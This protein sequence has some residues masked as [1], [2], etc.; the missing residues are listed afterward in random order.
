[1]IKVIDN[2]SGIVLN[3]DVVE[4][5]KDVEEYLDSWDADV[6]NRESESFYGISDEDFYNVAM[7]YIL[8]AL[9]Y[10]LGSVDFKLVKSVEDN[11]LSSKFDSFIKVGDYEVPEY[12][13]EKF[14]SAEGDLG[15]FTMLI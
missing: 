2:T 8:L 5:F 12:F 9:I 14:Y 4:I 7:E 10:V 11:E 6:F 1:M 13:I 3:D 15:V